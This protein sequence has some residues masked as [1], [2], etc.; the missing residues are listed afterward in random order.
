MTVE[1]FSRE[2]ISKVVQRVLQEKGITD[3]DL[4]ATVF[5]ADGDLGNKL[6]ILDPSPS[7]P[8]LSLIHI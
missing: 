6:S 4:E 5:E 1:Y 7:L 3:E 8:R 2:E